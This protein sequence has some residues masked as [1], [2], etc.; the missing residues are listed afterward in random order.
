MLSLYWLD[1]IQSPQLTLVGEKALALSRLKQRNFPVLPGFVI[2]TAT[3]NAFINGLDD[4]ESLLADFPQSSLYIDIDNYQALQLV[5]RQ[6][7]QCILAANFSGEWLREIETAAQKLNSPALILRASP[8][9]SNYSLP[10]TGGLF[11]SEIIKNDVASLSRGIKKIWANLFTAKSL[12][13][14]Q[15][16]GIAIEKVQMA[17]IVQP[18]I[19]ADISG[20]IK[21]QDTGLIIESTWGLGHSLSGGQVLPDIYKLDAETGEIY[22]QNLGNKNLVYSIRGEDSSLAFKLFDNGEQDS[23]T[24]ERES[25]N[26]LWDL[27][28]RLAREYLQVR[29]MKWLLVKESPDSSP[30][31]YILGWDYSWGHL[32][33]QPLLKGMIASAGIVQGMVRVL[34]G[35][36]VLTENLGED[37]IL[38]TPAINPHW[39]PYL[40]SIKGIITERGGMTSHG[41]ILARELGIVCLV[42][43]NG[44]TSKLTSGDKIVVDGYKGIVSTTLS[45]V[46][47]GVTASIAPEEYLSS[48][49]GTKLMVN[50]SQTDKLG[51]VINLPVDGVGLLRGEWMILELLARKPL[52]Q[53]LEISKRDKFIE[54]LSL[55]MLTFA[56][57]F[58]P[59]PIFYRSWDWSVTE[60]EIDTG[61][62]RQKGTYGY[63]LEPIVFDIQLQALRR[64][65]LAGYG[66][67]NLILPFVRGVEEFIF[68]KNRVTQWQLFQIPAFKLWIMAEVPSVLFLMP[69]FAEAGVQGI[70]IGS[71]DLTRLMLGV[72]REDPLGSNYFNLQHQAL[73]VAL[74]QLITGANN[75]GIPC[76]I[77]G[78]GVTQYPDIIENL[79][80]WGITAISVEPEA[81]VDTY[82]AIARAER[83]LLLEKARNSN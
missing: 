11:P 76:S 21:L 8:L 80:K 25:L 81:V 27:W 36:T 64:V 79:V 49:L 70:A 75:A 2:S 48:P 1:R 65:Q 72:D 45:S 42:G 9:A 52:Q 3:F 33:N 35:E 26:L 60:R 67:F 43:V 63:T 46:A 61:F 16:L 4:T 83:R 14:W 59:K 24:L 23:Y 10:K 32:E 13:Y 53:W 29:S 82:S 73:S 12:F 19:N 37:T 55:L 31:V 77:C 62:L 68:C 71:N 78:H 47:P 22:E 56:R 58:S 6:M 44:A 57:A 34:D 40:K 38:V 28:H 50:L 66:N 20:T 41:A 7:R 51:D 74:Q 17:I 54:E 39:L 18:V 15:K 69:Y 30:S 5:A